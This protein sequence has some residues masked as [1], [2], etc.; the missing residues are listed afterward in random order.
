MGSYLFTISI[1]FI[2]F[3]FSYKRPDKRIFE[4]VVLVVCFIICFGYMTGTDWRAYEEIYDSYKEPDNFYWRFLFVEPLYLCLN[5]I[6]NEAQLSFWTFYLIIKV[7]IFYKVISIFRRI[8]PSNVCLL[9]LTFYLGFWG[10]MIFIDPPFRN[11]IAVYI[12]LCSIR[13]FYERDLKKYLLLCWLAI[14]FHYSAFL[15]IPLYFCN[16]SFSNRNIIIAF[17]LVNLLLLDADWVFALIGKLLFFLPQVAAK[18]ENYTI[19]GEAE[20]TGAGKILSLGYFIHIFFFIIILKFRKII[21]NRPYGNLIF[22]MG[23]LYIFIFRLGLTVLIFSRIQLF[24]SIFYSIAVALS[25]MSMKSNQKLFYVFI[26]YALAVFSN[27]N[28]MRSVYMVPYTN[29]FFY[30]DENLSFE[31][32]SNYNFIHSPYK[33]ID[34]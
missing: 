29:Y 5:I 28:Q 26:I 15:L 1:V 24:I 9:A 30:L 2:S 7:L 27:V 8:C 18:I 11:L 34:K 22:N 21:E 12:F 6:G 16:R 19:G 32:R 31:E 13:Y 20:T 23:I 33:E 14:L 25:L 4:F 17:V 10:V 3:L